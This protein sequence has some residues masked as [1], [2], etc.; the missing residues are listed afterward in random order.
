MVQKRS[1][2]STPAEA[3]P[4]SFPSFGLEG[5]NLN[6]NLHESGQVRPSG[7][8]GLSGLSGL[9][10]ASGS[11]VKVKS[12]LVQTEE[13]SKPEAVKKSFN[14]SE[15]EEKLFSLDLK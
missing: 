1:F 3:K 14:P 13:K 7:P 6:L 2:D 11:G 5:L 15:F 12:N 9:S 10:G 8:S 4:S